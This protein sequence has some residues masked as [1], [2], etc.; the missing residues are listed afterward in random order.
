[1]AEC[2]RSS[3][4]SSVECDSFMATMDARKSTGP[5]SKLMTMM[6]TARVENSLPQCGNLAATVRAKPS[7][8]PACVTCPIHSMF[9]RRSPV[10][11]LVV[12]A[13]NTRAEMAVAQ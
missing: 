2:M 6:E 9:L 13:F 12:G 4:R 1:M 11:S 8:T 3:A 10:I 7:A 5:M